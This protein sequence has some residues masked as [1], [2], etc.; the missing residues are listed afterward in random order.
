MAAPITHIVLTAKVFGKFFKHQKKKDFFIGTC[1]PDI[2]YLKIINRDK[3]HYQNISINDFKNDSSFLVGVKFHSL[4]DEVREKYMVKNKAYTL[5]QQSAFAPQSLKLLEDEMLYS[6]LKDWR[7]YVISEANLKKWHTLMKQY[8]IKR[9]DRK[10]INSYIRQIGFSE[11]VV[12]ET[13]KN[14][15]L[16]RQNPKIIKIINNLYNNFEQLIT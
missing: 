8:F 2:R 11:S 16:M 14:L 5:C 3:T 12:R 1:F 9:P 13:H 7:T 15:R 6:Y 4:L 10:T